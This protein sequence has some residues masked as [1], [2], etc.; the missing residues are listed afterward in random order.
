MWWTSHHNNFQVTGLRI[1][2]LLI[3]VTELAKKQDK[4]N[5]SINSN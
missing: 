4:N 3:K 2:S 1:T 5:K